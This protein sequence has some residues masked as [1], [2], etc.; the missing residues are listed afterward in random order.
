MSGKEVGRILAPHTV[1][2]PIWRG[3]EKS[4]AARITEILAPTP[5]ETTDVPSK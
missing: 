3:A 2:V 5:K 1:P 4:T